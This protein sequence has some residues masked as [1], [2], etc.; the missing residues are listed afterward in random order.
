MATFQEVRIGD[1]IVGGSFGANTGLIAGSIFYDKHSIVKDPFTGDFDEARAAYFLERVNKLSRRYGIQMALDV[2]AASSQAMERYLEFTCARTNLPILI[3]ASEAE[4][5]I[6]GLETAARLG[7]LNRCVYT[8]LSID[9][10]KSELEALVKN[11][12]ATVMILASDVGDPTPEGS[13]AMIETYFQPILKEIG[14]SVPIVDV[15]T[16]DPP[17]IGL[18]IRQI[19]EVRERYGYPAGCAFANCFP[20]WTSLKSL[21]N[22]WVNL[23]LAA[24]LTAIRAAGGDYLH[25]GIIEKAAV[26]AHAAGTAEMF[27]GYA[28]QELDGYQLPEGHALW[29]MF[30]LSEEEV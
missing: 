13:C 21:G 5:R 8:S 22:D 30:K 14:V 28:A 19:R 23:S 17:S 26:A 15:G 29:K 20:Q 7:V 25:Y 11:P 2:I 16:M 3:N 18:N 10:E 4:A 1:A 6:A 12:P 9:T 27:Y 24:S